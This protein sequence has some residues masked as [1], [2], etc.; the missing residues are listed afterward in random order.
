VLHIELRQRPHVARAFNLT[1]TELL[2]RFLGPHAAG[3]LIRYADR[4]WEPRKTRVT[5][6]EGEELGPEQIGMGRGWGNAQRGGRDVTEEL[7]AR[8][9]GQRAPHRENPQE[10]IELDRLKER[11]RGRVQAGPLPLPDIV[12]LADERLEEVRVS[13]RLGLAELAVWELLREGVLELR[14]DGLALATPDWAAAL[15]AWEAWRSDAI[16]VARRN[17]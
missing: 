11:L 15:L 9:G 16:S 8:V 2:E 3:R 7:L 17:L 6:L 5:V 12:V 10:R 1:E 13:V 14:R 4:E